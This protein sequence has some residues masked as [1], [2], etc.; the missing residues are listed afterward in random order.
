MV[1]RMDFSSKD[2]LT[3]FVNALYT[4]KIY[5]PWKAWGFT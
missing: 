2:A 1:D 4:V 3:N 5:F